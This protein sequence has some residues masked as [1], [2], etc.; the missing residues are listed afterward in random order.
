MQLL[1]LFRG[2][3]KDPAAAQR[4]RRKRAA[5]RALAARLRS[6]APPARLTEPVLDHWWSLADEDKDGVLIAPEAVAFLNLSGL[7]REALARVWCVALGRPSRGFLG[8]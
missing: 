6:E 8:V 3:E 4:R 7:P 5:K 1:S 2:G